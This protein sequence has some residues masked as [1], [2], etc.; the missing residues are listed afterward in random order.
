MGGMIHAVSF[1][2]EKQ[3]KYRLLFQ[4]ADTKNIILLQLLSIDNRQ[5]NSF[6]LAFRS[7]LCQQHESVFF[8]H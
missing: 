4:M 6:A 8:L 2:F 7:V 5:E 3:S 1:E